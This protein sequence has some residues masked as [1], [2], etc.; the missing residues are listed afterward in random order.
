MF[1]E[2]FLAGT[3]D[4]IERHGYR[5]LSKSCKKSIQMLNL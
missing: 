3:P 5:P 1:R 2:D 4:V